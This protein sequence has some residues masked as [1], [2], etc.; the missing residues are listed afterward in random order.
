MGRPEPSGVRLPSMTTVTVP[1]L[2]MTILTLVLVAVVTVLVTV[3][4]GDSLDDPLVVGGLVTLWVTRWWLAWRSASVPH[5]PYLCN[6]P[7]HDPQHTLD[8]TTAPPVPRG[9]LARAW[10]RRGK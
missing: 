6:T 1:R 10:A 5:A 7:Q 2:P 9:P 8:P 3:R 4:R